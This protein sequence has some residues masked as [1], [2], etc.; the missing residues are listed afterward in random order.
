M[1]RKRFSYLAHRRGE[2]INGKSRR[3]N[4]VHDFYALIFPAFIPYAEMKYP[5]GEKSEMQSFRN[6]DFDRA[7]GTPLKAL[8]L[9]DDAPN[10]K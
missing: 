2:K 10:G 8:Q 1:P 9:H 5:W 7:E 4:S 3:K 6:A